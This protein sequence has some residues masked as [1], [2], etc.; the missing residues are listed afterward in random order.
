MGNKVKNASAVSRVQALLQAARKGRVS[1]NREGDM[2]LLPVVRNK[3]FHS[4]AGM[5]FVW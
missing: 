2:I 3:K 5:E 4:G 1:V